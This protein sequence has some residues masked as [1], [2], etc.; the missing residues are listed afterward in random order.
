MSG[1]GLDPE[2]YRIGRFAGSVFAWCEA[3]RGGAKEMSLSS[4]FQQ[5]DHNLLLPYVERATEENDVRFH[6]EKTLMTTDLFADFDMQGQWVFIIY[7]EKKVLEDYIALKAEK[8]RLEKEGDYVGE[9]R[10]RIARG[11]GGLLGYND[12]YIEE[13]LKRVASHV[14]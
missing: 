12:T 14:K 1:K 8:E 6:L 9:A 5:E 10:L 2:S 3:A 7:K 13:R 4:P 11:M